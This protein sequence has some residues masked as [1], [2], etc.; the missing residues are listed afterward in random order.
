M[1]IRVYDIPEMYAGMMTMVR[2]HGTPASSRNGD[3]L[4][5][6]EPVMVHVK[7]PLERVLTDP[8][9]DANPFFHVMEFV[10][11][12]AGRNDPDFLVQFVKRFQEY[13]DT[14][15]KTG[16]PL[17]HGAYGFRWR[18]H[19]N[20][21]QIGVAVELLK[22]SPDT[23]RVVLGMWDPHVD[24]G[25]NHNDLP[26][27]THIY[28]DRDGSKLNMLVCNRSN[29]VIWGM[30]GANAVHMTFLQELMADALELDVGR[31][32]VVTNNAHVYLDLP[33][34]DR[35]IS[36]YDAHYF[37]TEPGKRKHVSLLN[38]EEKLSHFLIE[39]SYF[40]NGHM[41]YVHNEWLSNVAFP[42]YE[43]WH[44]REEYNPELITDTYWREACNHWLQRRL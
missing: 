23:R 13:A 15:N 17:L 26:C 16:K 30:T 40:C 9:R 11:M 2:Y 6:E 20:T 25:T 4:V 42:I 8:I 36:T 35:M 44:N 31:Y 27:N 41:D 24:L 18:N 19:F 34:V 21:D 28:V 14:N 29:D 1:E 5:I 32:S 33:N 22:N 7:N 43:L 10:W 39:C 12:M 37:R 3:V 38:G